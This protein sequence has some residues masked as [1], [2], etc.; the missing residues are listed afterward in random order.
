MKNKNV[1]DGDLKKIGG[2]DLLLKNVYDGRAIAKTIQTYPMYYI[3]VNN[4]E[5]Y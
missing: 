4:I 2:D 3:I 5:N 1:Y